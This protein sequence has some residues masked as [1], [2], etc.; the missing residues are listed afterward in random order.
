MNELSPA[1][2]IAAARQH[3][4][5]SPLR[6]ARKMSGVRLYEVAEFMGI[7]QCNVSR[8]EGYGHRPGILICLQYAKFYGTTV[9]ALFG[10]LSDI[11]ERIPNDPTVSNA[12][13]YRHGRN[14]YR[15][16]R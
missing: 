8:H 16:R 15:P 3:G 2:K 14:P 13:Q 11:Y 6:Q 9:D 4:T 5:P 12:G 10:Y 1:A 7:N